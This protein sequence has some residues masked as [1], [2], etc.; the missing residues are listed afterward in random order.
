MQERCSWRSLLLRTQKFW[1]WDKSINFSQ[2]KARARHSF[3][4]SGKAHSA[5]K[6]K[7]S[8]R[9]LCTYRDSKERPQNVNSALPSQLSW[10]RGNSLQ[11][12]WWHLTQDILLSCFSLLGHLQWSISSSRCL[13]ANSISVTGKPF[14]RHLLLIQPQQEAKEAF[15]HI[16]PGDIYFF[17]EYT[18]CKT[19]FLVCFFFSLFFLFCFFSCPWRVW[20]YFSCLH[21]N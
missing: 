11:D 1:I 4:V 16:T 8:L 19:S 10:W 5:L 3:G 7:L 15:S 2:L 12:I 13:E 21:L 18:V 9:E 14:Q 17:G 6:P 20:S